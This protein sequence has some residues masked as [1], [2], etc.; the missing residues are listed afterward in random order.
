MLLRHC[1]QD[2]A[3]SQR[4][5]EPS[6]RTVRARPCAPGGPYTRAPW[7]AARKS[8]SRR[9]SRLLR[10][11]DRAVQTVERALDL[12]GAPST[13]ARRS[14]TTS[15]SSSSCASGAR[16]SSTPRQRCPRGDGRV[17]GPRVAPS[18]HAGASERRLETIDATCPLVTKVH[19]EA[20]KFAAEGLHD[21][22]DRARRPRGGRGH[23][24]RG[25]RPDR[26]R[27]E[28]G[29]RRRARGRGSG[30]G[31]LTSRRRRCRWT[32]PRSIIDRLRERFPTI[33]GPRTDD[34]CYATTN[35]QAA[36]KELARH[37]DLVLV[38]GSRNSS[39]SNRLVEVAREHGVDSH[40]IDNEGRL[41]EDWLEDKRVVG[42]HLRRERPGGA[43]CS[44]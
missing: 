22:A 44:A 13:F 23:D 18:V 25:P 33:V 21:R 28:R 1:A 9:A 30:Q 31:R 24:G 27:R 35:R 43:S 41:Q 12:Y 4:P 16:S 3:E 8:C 39:N 26:A 38:I 20:R 29:G 7:V 15:T 10:G 36:V 32:R 37:C 2:Y 19:V 42:H 11:V 17:L 40:L 6:R 14:C 34:I 5:G